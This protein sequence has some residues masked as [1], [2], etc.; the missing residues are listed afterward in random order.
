LGGSGIGGTIAKEILFDECIAPFDVSKSYTI[1]SYV[2][3]NTLVICSSYSGNTE[4]TLECYALAQKQKAKIVCITSGGKILEFAKKDGNDYILVP[5][6]MPPRSCLGYSLTQVL[7]ILS[8]YKLA[9]QKSVEI[10]AAAEMLAKEQEAIINEAHHIVKML[11][12]KMPV[13]YCTALHEGIAIRFRQQLN[14]NAKILCWH[15]VV[16]EM[17]H[18]ELVGW[19]HAYTDVAVVLFKDKDENPRNKLRMDF[20]HKVFEKYAAEIIEIPSKG[21]NNIEKKLYWI[22]LGDWVSMFLSEKRNVDA[23]DIKVID[24]L[25][26]ELADKI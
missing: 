10:A 17:N 15:H 8:H 22:H 23:M 19:S 16:P 14:E 6:G 26:Q 4:E 5:G 18:N 25:K 7:H 12:D 9:P 3:E 11:H 13:I 20:C 21:E 1:P 24:S 2:D